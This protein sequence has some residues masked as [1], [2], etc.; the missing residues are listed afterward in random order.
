R[1]GHETGDRECRGADAISSIATLPEP[2]VIA[3]PEP[4]ATYPFGEDLTVT[5]D[6]SEAGDDM[7][8]KIESNCLQD[9]L[10]RL[11]GDPGT[12]TIPAEELTPA[13]EPTNLP[14]ELTVIVRRV[15]EGFVDANFGEGGTFEATQERT[16]VSNLEPAPAG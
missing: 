14:C 8:I 9:R 4:G 2:F 5:W 10:E 13:M 15:R 16:V 7:E 3:S 1:G 6:A 11:D 12:Y